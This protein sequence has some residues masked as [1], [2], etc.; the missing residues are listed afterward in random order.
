MTIW[1]CAIGNCGTRF[2]TVERAIDHQER[3]HDHRECRVCRAVVPDGYR[4]I[5]HVFGE[6]TRAQYVRAYE[7]DAGAIRVREEVR[8]RVG[9]ALDGSNGDDSAGRAGD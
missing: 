7:A 8:S 2:E 6:H 3:D 1:E 9:A 5:E 4:A